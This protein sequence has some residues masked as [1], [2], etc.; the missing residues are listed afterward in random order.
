MNIITL[1][2]ERCHCSVKSTEPLE[3]LEGYLKGLGWILEAD[4]R[5][6]ICVTCVREYIEREKL[7]HCEECHA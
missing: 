2:C 6:V 4:S 1:T 3:K 7:S 5:S